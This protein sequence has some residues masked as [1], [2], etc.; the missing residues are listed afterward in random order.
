MSNTNISVERLH[1]R[2]L[3]KQLAL[4]NYELLTQ[5]V[6]KRIESGLTQKDVADL[7]EVSQQ[8]ISKFESLE[9]DP[10]LSTISKYAMALNVLIC[11]DVQDFDSPGAKRVSSR[12][13]SQPELSRSPT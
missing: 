1:R 3:A 10:R 9:M 7:L 8:S 12:Q 6:T 4:Q 13:T 5:L 11:H 2:N